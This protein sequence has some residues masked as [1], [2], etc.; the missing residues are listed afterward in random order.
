M[1]E[2]S[3][4]ERS[5]ALADGF[6]VPRDTALIPH[7][8]ASGVATCEFRTS[9]AV[10]L[11]P[12]TLESVSYTSVLHDIADLRIPTLEPIRALLKLRLRARSVSFERLKLDSLPLFIAGR[13]EVGAR[14][15]EQLVTSASAAVVRWGQTKSR[16]KADNTAFALGPRPVRPFGMDPDQALLPAVHPAFEGY[17]LLQEYFACPARF[18][19]VELGGLAE[20]TARCQEDSLE[21]LVAL[22][23]LDPTLEHAVD[24]DRVR[25]FAT[26]A[27]NLFPRICSRQAAP[28]R[29]SEMQV[30][31]DQARPFDFEVH[32]ATRVVAHSDDGA[33]AVEL[34][35]RSSFLDDELDAGFSY[36]LRRR[37][38]PL[39][40][41]LSDA[42]SPY[43]AS[44]VYLSLFRH[45]NTRTRREPRQL[46]VHAL[47]T[48]RDLARSLRFGGRPSDFEV[49]SGVPVDAV[50]CIVP[51]TAPRSA[52]PEGESLWRFLSYLNVN[53][54][55]LS[56][57]S[58]GVEA[59][60][61]LLGLFAQLGDPAIERQIHAVQGLRS[62]SIIG[63]FPAPGPRSFVRG[64]QVTLELEEQ[65]FG[66]HGPFTLAAVLSRLFARHMPLSSFTQTVLT[67]RERG[68]VY[69]WPPVAGLRHVI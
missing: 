19:F 45:G 23:R 68:E 43:A 1:V 33:E 42:R 66:A 46:S 2:F 4:D 27:I 15:Y 28:R 40:P 38:T 5:S 47:C 6:T 11:L 69:R 7:T 50:R 9:H 60:R 29:G 53:Y 10:K 36:M 3:V 67:T 62:S 16:A 31:V 54:L 13:D 48:N 58:G 35:P 24:A 32:S 25:L 56:E 59:L 21:L 51:P 39:P 41:T 12:I 44:D 17:R 8:E 37:P 34:E 22:T 65:A 20:A 18:R 63:P 55:A 57:Q 30:V 49:R 52:Q 14:L 64:L 61:E 26:P